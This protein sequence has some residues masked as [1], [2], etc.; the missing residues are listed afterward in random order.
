MAIQ[1]NLHQAPRT[2]ESCRQEAPVNPGLWKLI[3]ATAAILLLLV[4]AMQVF[5]EAD[6]GL[7]F[8]SPNPHGNH[9]SAL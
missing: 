2:A 3:A 6:K 8:Q 5:N 9:A 1:T 4:G 7:A